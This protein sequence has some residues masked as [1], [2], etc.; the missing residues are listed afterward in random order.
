MRDALSLFA[1]ER[2][3]SV[4]EALGGEPALARLVSAFYRRM[5]AD[6]AFSRLNRLHVDLPRAE[7]LLL[8]FLRFRLGG[9]DTY[10]QER[11]HPRLRMRHAPFAIGEVERDQWVAC[12]AAAMAEVG[13][14]P[15]LQSALHA[16]FAQVAEHMRNR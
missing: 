1:H 11:G 12:M 15:E 9:P 16:F 8:G 6:P 2:G 14:E 5:A 4:Y 10:L 7:H 13:V 3:A